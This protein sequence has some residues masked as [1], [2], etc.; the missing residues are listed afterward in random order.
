M[1]GGPSA[2]T[3]RQNHTWLSCCICLLLFLIYWF[4]DI[5]YWFLLWKMK[6]WSSYL[7]P[8][9]PFSSLHPLRTGTP[10]F[11]V[12]SMWTVYDYIWFTSDQS[13]ILRYF[14]CCRIFPWN[15]I[16]FLFFLLLVFCPVTSSS[17]TLQW[18]SA[19]PLRSLFP[20]IKL[21]GLIRFSLGLETAVTGLS[22]PLLCLNEWPSGP[23][24]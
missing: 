15:W 9:P 22:L 14:L 16:S 4:L 2:K 24:A 8:R 19:A 13:G 1:L 20:M 10:H 17:E 18:N 7:T 5:I 21:Q 6:I 12:N 23:A 11:L 3:G